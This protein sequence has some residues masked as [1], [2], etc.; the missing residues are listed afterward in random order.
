MSPEDIVKALADIDTPHVYS[1]DY[2]HE[3]FFCGEGLSTRLEHHKTTCLWRVATEWTE[4]NS[5]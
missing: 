5:E 1:G 3:C 2:Y 4:R